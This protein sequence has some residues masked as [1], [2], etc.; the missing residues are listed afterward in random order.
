M[1]KQASDTFVT[2][3]KLTEQLESFQVP[4]VAIGTLALL[5]RN[6]QRKVSCLLQ[7][8]QKMI[9]LVIICSLVKYSGSQ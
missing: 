5:V 2:N 6:P 1:T 3:D 8:F 9:D 7:S 4:L